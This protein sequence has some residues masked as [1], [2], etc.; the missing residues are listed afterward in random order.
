MTTA[1]HVL[2]VED[3]ADAREMYATY[4]G[5]AGFQISEA[6]DGEQALSCAL[7]S[8][9]DLIVLDLGLPKIDGLTVAR[10]LRAEAA[11]AR[12]PII[13]LSANTLVNF[14]P[15]ALEAGCSLALSKPCLPDELLFS[16]RELLEQR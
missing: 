16:I 13:A 8:P 6:A 1:A 3:Y 15:L 14:E 7:S 9:P 4:Q 11:T 10:R 2:L 5:R 12:V